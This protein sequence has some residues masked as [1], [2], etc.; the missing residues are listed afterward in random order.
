MVYSTDCAGNIGGNEV[1]SLTEGQGGDAV[2]FER[3]ER[4]MGLYRT[5]SFSFV[6]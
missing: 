5:I 4:N 1:S 3:T 2:H 6:F